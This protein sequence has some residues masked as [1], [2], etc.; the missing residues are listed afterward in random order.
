MLLMIIF[1]Y[2]EIYY[3]DIWVLGIFQAVYLLVISINIIKFKVVIYGININNYA[4]KF[5]YIIIGSVTLTLCYL[6]CA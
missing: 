5:I 3:R 4:E 6:V 2:V 1:E